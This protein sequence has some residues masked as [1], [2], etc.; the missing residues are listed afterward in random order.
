M[1][2]AEYD[3]Q[4]KYFHHL[5]RTAG[6]TNDR[7]TQ[8][9]VKHFGAT[10]WNVLN[11]DQKRAAINMM[12]RYAETGRAAANKKLRS[13]IVAFGAKHGHNK[14]QLYE[15]LGITAEHS[16]SKMDFPE[17][18]EVWNQVQILFNTEK[19]GGEQRKAE[20]YNKEEKSKRGKEINTKGAEDK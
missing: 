2:R 6:W 4:G 15:V 20:G 1:P 18:A 10:H 3:K 5:V 19:S 13:R 8:L 7:V 9:F 12:R 17:L 16:L 11:A 14:E